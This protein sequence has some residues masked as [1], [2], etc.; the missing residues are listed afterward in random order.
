MT[1]KEAVIARSGSDEAIQ[2]DR[3]DC[4]ASVATARFAH[5]AMTI[6]QAG[7]LRYA[8]SE[9]LRLDAAESSDNSTAG[10]RSH[11]FSHFITFP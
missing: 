1:K 4:R 11:S 10:C 6:M 9:W 5:L 8:K 3:D 2:L 7:R